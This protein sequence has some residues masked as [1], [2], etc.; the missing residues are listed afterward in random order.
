[1]TWGQFIIQFQRGSHYFLSLHTRMVQRLTTHFK[2]GRQFMNEVFQP[3]VVDGSGKGRRV[4][5]FYTNLA[6]LTRC[7]ILAPL[8]FW[9]YIC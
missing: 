9:V 3:S 6:I 2:L 5:M 8:S 7:T 4:K 1:M